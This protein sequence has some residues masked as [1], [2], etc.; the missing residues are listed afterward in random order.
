MS[1][2][3]HISPGRYVIIF[4]ISDL[5]RWEL[6]HQLASEFTQEQTALGDRRDQGLRKV[7]HGDARWIGLKR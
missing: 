2:N 4:F 3:L 1:L 7:S 5:Q 6:S